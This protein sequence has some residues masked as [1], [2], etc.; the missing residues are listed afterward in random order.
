MKAYKWLG[1][2]GIWLTGIA[3]ASNASH[4]VDAFLAQQV[5]QQLE[6]L[7]Q[8]IQTCD[9]LKDNAEPPVLSATQLQQWSVSHEVLVNAIGYLSQHNDFQC[10]QAERQAAVYAMG[11]YAAVSANA[12]EM[13]TPVSHGLLYPSEQYYQLMIQFQTLPQAAQQY[14]QQQVGEAPFD[15]LAAIRGLPN[16][17]E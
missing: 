2:C 13:L 8:R 6:V 15:L 10:H 9:A 14:L 5:S 4:D 1:L 11:A 16:A 7:A 17:S 3:A 12:D